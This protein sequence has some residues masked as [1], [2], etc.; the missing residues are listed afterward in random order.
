MNKI[1]LAF[2]CLLLFSS[3]LLAKDKDK[4]REFFTVTKVND[5]NSVTLNNGQTIQLTGVRCPSPDD[6]NEK[7]K[8]WGVAAKVFLEKM[9]LNQKVW[10]SGQKDHENKTYAFVLFVSNLER[11][12]GVVDQGYM[13]FWGTAGKF[14][15]NRELVD[16][17]FCSTSSPFSFKY[18]SQFNELEKTA[19]LKQRGMWTDF[20]Q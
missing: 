4:D 9:I 7:I 20:A 11:M 12:S 8:K 15:A 10:L 19:R 13:P 17:G 16:N 2:L 14:M 5:G 3:P 18:R 6:A 1:L